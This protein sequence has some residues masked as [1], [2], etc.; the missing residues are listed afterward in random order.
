MKQTDIDRLREICEKEG[1]EVSESHGS[2]L[3]QI[4]KKDPWEGV[5]FE[6]CVISDAL[7]RYTPGQIY[8]GKIDGDYFY[9]MFDNNKFSNG[10]NKSHFK[11]S[12]EAAYVSQLKE[13][14]KELYGEICDGD[15]FEREWEPEI[16]RRRIFAIGDKDYYK[17]GFS[18]AK[19][20]DMFMF[21]GHS[22]YKQGKWAKKIERVRVGMSWDTFKDNKVFIH[23]H[24]DTGNPNEI[25][26]PL[27]FEDNPKKVKEI[28]D[29][30]AK[31]LEDKLNEA[32]N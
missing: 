19:D 24:K 26:T 2:D 14:A 21:N 7:G 13:K 5:E 31:C 15:R 16:D 25:G 30:L 11:P 9:T 17:D 10:R 6:E 23:F 8:P 29:Y 22:I 18:Y 28:G 4:S 32:G 27:L 3:F 1:F 20:I 12:T